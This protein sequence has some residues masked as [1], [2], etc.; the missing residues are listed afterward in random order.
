MYHL[1][2]TVRMEFR[3][4]YETLDAAVAATKRWRNND[5]ITDDFQDMIDSESFSMRE[6]NLLADQVIPDT[7]ERVREDRATLV[8]R[9]FSFYAEQPLGTFRKNRR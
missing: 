1:F 7:S 6:L 3:G 4:N 5:Y 2:D 8:S 9:L